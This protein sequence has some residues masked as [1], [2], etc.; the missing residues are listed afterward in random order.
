MTTFR[1]RRGPGIL[2]AVLVLASLCGP[3]FSQDWPQWRGPNRDGVAAGFQ[4]PKSWP[5]Q[6]KLKWKATV[7]EGY[8]SPTV[9]GRQVFLL[10]RQ[11]EQEVVSSFDLET[12]KLLWRDSYP[13]AYEMN[14]AARSHGKGPKSTPVVGGGRLYTLGIGGVLS[15]YDTAAGKLRW[16]KEFGQT[17]PLYGTAMSPL[18]DGRLLIAHVGGHGRGALTAFDAETGAVRW[19]WDG[20]GP[21]YASPI[22]VGMDGVRQVVTQSQDHLAGVSAADGALLWKLPFRTPYT[23]N[24]VTP[25]LHR[26]LLIFSGLGQGVFAVRV[27]RQGNGWA[28]A[29]VWRNSDVS[30]YMNSPVLAGNLLFGMSHRNKGQFF[31]LDAASGKTLWKDDGRQGENA[32]VLLAGAVLL[33]LTNDGELIVT[34]PTDKG[35]QPVQ[36]YRVADSATWA[37]PALVGN[38][39]LVKD[40]ATLALWSVE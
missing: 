20:D 23:Q 28:A 24:I 38:R 21:G 19:S 34:H 16:R 17:S 12:G 3:C 2:L 7:G 5:A 13:A 10:S 31:C 32:A 27:A 33:I 37:H 36:R 4:A 39:I 9:A 22:A 35:L 15:C 18:L 25:V 6:L 29:E 8:S 14:P 11:G 26:D 1:G 40:A 30:M